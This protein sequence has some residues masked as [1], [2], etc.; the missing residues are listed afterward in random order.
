MTGLFSGAF[1]FW[2]EIFVKSSMW[3]FWRGIFCLKILHVV[4]VST[5]KCMW[6]E[7]GGG[8]LFS[9]VYGNSSFI[10]TENKCTPFVFSAFAGSSL[11]KKKKKEQGS[12]R[13]AFGYLALLNLDRSIRNGFYYI[14]CVDISVIKP[15]IKMIPVKWYDFISLV[16]WYHITS[17]VWIGQSNR[18]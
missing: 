17:R 15:W 11:V 6:R 14:L 16:K 18:L 12:R 8:R 7:G 1:N 13:Y 2:F 5:Q 10:A 4:S 3:L 9:E